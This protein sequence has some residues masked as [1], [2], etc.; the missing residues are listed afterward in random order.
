MPF[1]QVTSSDI[2]AGTSQ[3]LPHSTPKKRK[4][5][6][7]G[8]ADGGHKKQHTGP[9][10]SQIP[11]SLPLEPHEA[12]LAELRPRFEIRTL[13]VISS[14]KIEQ[15][16]SAVLS[17]LG[18]FHPTDMAILPGVVLIHAR[19]HEVAKMI[20]IV[21]IVRRRVH[22]SGQKWYQYNRLYEIETEAPTEPSIIEETVL[23]DDVAG[24]PEENQ[25]ADNN[26]NDDGVENIPPR[27]QAAVADKKAKVMATTYMSIFLSRV[28]VPEL[29][30]KDAVTVQ[31]NEVQ[32]E[33]Q[34]RKRMGI[35]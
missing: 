26:D 18:R 35:I 30:A 2:I 29:Q 16:V 31:S 23:M 12:I 6:S 15:R 32:I 25:I 10:T 11:H 20:S 21:E 24:E 28:P 3:S 4:R 19:S 13:S 33:E 27:F 1:A 9:N 7:A 8:A 17:H 34:R 22:E 5:E 14:S